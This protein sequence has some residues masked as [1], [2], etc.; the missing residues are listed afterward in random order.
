[1]LAYTIVPILCVVKEVSAVIV[2]L[3]VIII[4]IVIIVI[5]IDTNSIVCGKSGRSRSSGSS[6]KTACSI[7]LN[8]SLLFGKRRARGNGLLSSKPG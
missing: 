5:A 4:V 1:L 8:G 6:R 7:I 3:V 2:V